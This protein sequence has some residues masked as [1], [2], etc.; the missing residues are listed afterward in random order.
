MAQNMTVDEMEQMLAERSAKRFYDRS[1]GTRAP[2]TARNILEENKRLS[3]E[4]VKTKQLQRQLS[5]DTN[6]LALATERRSTETEKAKD[7]HRLQ[8]K[9]DLADHYRGKIFEKESEKANEYTRKVDGGGDIQF[10][11]FVE[12]EEIKKSRELQSEKMR[13]EMQSFLAQQRKQQTPR[14][15]GM[16]EAFGGTRLLYPVAPGSVVP[17]EGKAPIALEPHS[18][19][20]EPPPQSHEEVAPHMQRHP[21]FLSRAREHMSRRLH[22]T[23]VR[24]VLE[25]KVRQTKEELQA[26]KAILEAERRQVDEGLGVM[27][28]LRNDKR[29][30]TAAARKHHQ[31]YLKHQIQEKNAFATSEQNEFRAQPAGYW[32]PDDKPPQHDEANQLLRKD[33]VKQI[34][35]D[36]HRRADEKTRRLRLEKRLVD[37]CMA[38][39]SQDREKDKH[40]YAQHRDVLVTTWESQQK[41]RNAMRVVE[42]G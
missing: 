13:Q 28:S 10:F 15:N 21:R 32:G 40:K 22:D 41:I 14:A 34:E 2:Q 17:M 33:L 26:R 7:I 29:Q 38:E 8:T 24:T 5:K 11:P 9:R 39:M 12:G 27:D 42:N 36:V 6:E 31:E 19:R 1:L 37:N 20:S 16:L 4:K 25:E 18:A 35:V 30:Y 23:H 3:Q